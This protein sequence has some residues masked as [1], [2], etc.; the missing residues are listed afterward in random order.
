MKRVLWISRHVMTHDQLAD[1]ERIMGGPVILIPWRDTV[2]DVFTLTAE[3]QKADA[4]AAVL[5]PEIL[6]QLVHLAEG[7]PV[8]QAVSERRPTGRTQTTPDG[9][10]EPEFAF[11]HHCWQQIL[12]IEIK[13]KTL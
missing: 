13:T 7:K 10:T 9:R 1:L 5:P 12:R 2:R 4:V 3:V 8:L 6:S 11:V